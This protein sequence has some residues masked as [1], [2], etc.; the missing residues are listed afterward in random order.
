MRTVGIHDIS[1]AGTAVPEG[2]DASL[3][4]ENGGSSAV[5]VNGLLT[6]YQTKAANT[7]IERFGSDR[8]FRTRAGH[9]S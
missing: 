1:D 9:N 3:S 2:V 7:R 4:S 6:A 5:Y 8:I